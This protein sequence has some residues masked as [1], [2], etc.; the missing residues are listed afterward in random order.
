MLVKKFIS[1]LFIFTLVA[2]VS[3]SQET[4]AVEQIKWMSWNEAIAVQKLD[5]DNF[6]ADKKANPAP[7]KIFLDI[8]TGWCGWC[9]K[10]DRS[11][12]KAPE[13]VKYMNKYFYAIKLDAEMTETISYNGHD[14]INPR[15]E[16]VRGRKGTHQLAAS[17]LD[18]RLS[19][20]SYVIMDENTNRLVIYKGYKQTDAF[21]GILSFFGTNQHLSYKKSL[22]KQAKGPQQQ[23]AA[24]KTDK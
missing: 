24:P 21:V 13:V 4:V 9:K 15:P 7:K 16:V 6:N 8:Y 12:F 11:T 22:S 5:R 23:V 20:P 14:F 18:N 3:F 2:P 19:Y 1:I 10:M 17:L